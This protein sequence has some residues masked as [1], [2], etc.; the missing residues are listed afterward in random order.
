MTETAYTRP[1]GTLAGLD[2]EYGPQ[3]HILADP[4]SLSVAA[5]LGHPDTKPPLFHLL[6]E[7]AFRRMLQASV[8]LLPTVVTRVPTRME[9]HVP[10]AAYEGVILDPSARV[11]LVD[12]ARG[13]MI[14]SYVC[15]R[16][17]HQV[18]DP[19]VVRV[20]H[21]YMQRVTGED[22]RVT[23]VRT[24]GS[25]IGGPVAGAT[26]IVPD[27]MGATGRSMVDA[28]TVFQNMEGGPPARMI[29]FHLLITPEYLRRVTAAFPQLHIVA[30]RLDRGMSPPDVLATRLGAR[31]ADER[32]L[33]DHDY[34]VPGAGGL[35]ELINNAFV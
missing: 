21:L 1:V 5:R 6:L 25:K 4:W 9:Q 8:E 17:L 13:G 27:P 31:G 12:V 22:G 10:G 26:L 11:V 34:I 16:E 20:D 30:L 15:Q 32:G 35:G 33:S 28:L 2:H 29:A 3:V 14:P 24:S 7:S 19:D 18:L 23:G